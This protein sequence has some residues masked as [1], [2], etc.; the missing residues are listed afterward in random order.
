MDAFAFT[1]EVLAPS[2][3]LE[4]CAGRCLLPIFRGAQERAPPAT[5]AKPL[6][7][8]DGGVG[9]GTPLNS[10]SIYKTSPLVTGPGSPTR[11]RA[12]R[13]CRRYKSPVVEELDCSRYSRRPRVLRCCCGNPTSG[14]LKSRSRFRLHLTTG[15]T[16]DS[17]RCASAQS[18]QL[19]ISARKASSD[20]PSSTAHRPNDDTRRQSC[21]LWARSEI[22]RVEI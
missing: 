19:P 11:R 1:R 6:R 17:P 10:P 22:A 7:G 16:A 13:E 5:T 15:A 2:A 8:D 9:G 3:S 4:G 20:R 14:L 18:V 21:I 12:P